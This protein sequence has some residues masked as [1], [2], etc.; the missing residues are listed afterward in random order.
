MNQPSSRVSNGVLD[1]IGG[2]PLVRLNR[3]LDRPD[4]ELIVK[5]EAANPGGS[6]K[7]RPAAKMLSEALSRG[8]IGP[9]TTI[10][11]STSG[12]LKRAGTTD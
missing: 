8:E 12:W 9:D 7:D 2:T 1:A 4:I 6:A 5:W 10:V 11:E 3:F